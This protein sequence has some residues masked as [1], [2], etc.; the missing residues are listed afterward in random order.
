[1]K[2]RVGLFL[3]V[4]WSV[5][6]F[7]GC[8][9]VVDVEVENADE[10][11]VIDASYNATDEIVRVKITRSIALFGGQD[12]EP[13]NGAVIEVVTPG[14]EVFI[15]D[16]L[17]DGLYEYSE[18]TPVYNKSY[19]MKA[20]VD[21]MDFEA[22][23]LL[24]NVVPLDSLS[25]EFQEASLF[26]DEG[27]VVYMN[28][29]DPGGENFYRANREV[30]GD[31]LSDLEDQFLFDNMFS[32]GNSQRV[33]FF[34]SRYK[35]GDTINVSL[36]SYSEAVFRYYSDLFDL[37]FDSGESAAPANPRTN[38]NNGALGVFN[39]FG[40]DKKTIVIKE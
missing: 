18:L 25:Q 5:A 2:C 34:G 19:V 7:S 22:T 17:G 14:D 9:K 27:Y 21:G 11:I 20:V 24:P 40:Y 8:E 35:V 12:F 10:N 28:L 39:V 38:W 37:A 16:E 30:N 13:V 6:L 33:P 3:M 36:Q 26:G 4:I 32:E 23:A 29:T 1:M 31:T 15:L